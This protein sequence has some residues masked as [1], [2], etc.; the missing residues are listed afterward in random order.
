MK[1]A[2]LCIVF[3]LLIM[4]GCSGVDTKGT[5]AELRGRKVTVA[6]EEIDNGIDKAIASYQ[7]FLEDSKDVALIPEAIRRLADLKVEK[8]YGLIPSDGS[9]GENQ[10]AD[11]ETSR[12]LPL[13]A[14]K[15]IHD[16]SAHAAVFTDAP[17]TESEVD[18]ERFTEAGADSAIDANLDD[19]AKA[20][21]LEAIAL[22][23]KLLD[24]F[25]HYERNDQV[26]YQMCR[27]YEELGRIEEAIEVMNRL[28]GE[29]P[30]S[31][32]IDEVQFRRGEYFFTRRLY[33][34][35]EDAYA[36]IVEIGVASS[37]YPLAVYKLGWTF[38]KQELYE[39]A[40]HRFI[41]L[42]DYK[43]SIGY[44]FDQLE[45]EQERKRMD[46]TFRV[47]SLGFSYLGGADSVVDYFDRYGER[48]YAANI[49][50]NLGEYYFVK[51][52]Y[53]DAVAS[54]S[55]FLNGNPFHEKSPLFQMRIVEINLAGGFPSLVIEAKK[56]Y[57]VKY[58][59]TADYWL[60]FEPEERPEVLAYLKNNL[61]DLANHYHALYQ[62][63]EQKK[64]KTINFEE[65]RHW[66][67]MFLASFSHD[68]ESPRINYQLADLLLE[69]RDFAAAAVEYERT[70]YAYDPHEQ[71]SKAGYAAVF[72][73]RQHLKFIPEA[74]QET[75]KREVI[76]SSLAFSATFP[77]HDKAAI[78][79]AAAADDLYAL[80][81]YEHAV[82]AGQT[83]IETFPA[84]D[85]AVTRSAWLVVAHSC[86][87]LEV[88]DEAETAY[89]RVLDLLPEQDTSRQ[90]LNDNLAVSIYRQGEEARDTGNF[91]I[92]AEHFLRVASK[93][94]TSNIRPTAEYD[95]AAALMQI[96]AWER[97]ATV[98]TAF[99]TNFPGH[100]L[101]R[102]VTRKIA[103]VYRES[104]RYEL[105]A[106]EF[107]RVAAESGNDDLRR[108][109]LL[110]AAELYERCADKDQA[111]SVYR[112]FVSSF[113]RPLEP[114]IETR[115][116]IAE[117]LKGQK[118]ENEYLAELSMIVSLDA[119]AGSDRTERTRYLAGF[120]AL[121]LAEKSHERF[122]SIKLIKPFE[123]NLRKKQ[124][125]MK[126][127]TQEFTALIDYEI[128]EITAAATYYLAEIYAHF[129][130]SLMESERP[131]GLSPL[132]SEEYDLAIE[133]Q[134]YPFEEKAI[135]V[136]ESN[137]E[138]IALGVY[139]RWVE[140][141][142]ARLAGFVPSRYAKPVEQTTIIA[143][144]GTFS[145]FI[146]GTVPV[147]PSGN[148]EPALEQTSAEHL[149]PTDGVVAATPTGGQAT[150]HGNGATTAAAEATDAGSQHAEL[151]GMVH[152][153]LPP[154]QGD[155][156]GK[157]PDPVQPEA[158]PSSGAEPQQKE[159]HGVQEGA[160]TE[161][162]SRADLRSVSEADTDLAEPI[163][164]L[165]QE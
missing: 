151:P 68:Q 3:M 83:L 134:A 44:D 10:A 153:H 141:S 93:A 146:A 139:N 31:R 110:V 2:V 6:E 46:D 75:V 73:Y 135:A 4:G 53:S 28:V 100:E 64:A 63:P 160:V 87:E 163:K 116:K 79:L 30:Q 117:L 17:S 76:R 137:L 50:A 57:A 111:L 140:K 37:F 11:F 1:R 13:A 128:G 120:S 38:Y 107:E 7:K 121:V 114:N 157:Q 88:F 34:D 112:R 81:D 49:Y 16:P 24:E 21:P 91:K 129:S 80:E 148:M 122:E 25:P 94:P 56:T 96:K 69:N 138:L 26:L 20:G 59:L 22:Y 164:S 124:K 159:S 97:A 85:S 15:A 136:H 144:P 113:P 23:Q 48:S 70:A 35:A 115:N 5:I 127:A 99:R 156:S 152:R 67:R 45:D 106:P 154:K 72:A 65:A 18:W 165:N 12:P 105:A 123:V 130:K 155:D 32:Y 33:L 51:R 41:A 78:V 77:R 125:Q 126:M 161:I 43:L 52:R 86:Y 54:Y 103:F 60:Y 90:T 55:A 150:L 9:H 39:E 95:A 118:R 162:V 71:A 133:E 131:E 66:Y 58:G 132:E 143:S 74:Q 119:A 108:E 8:E 27:A 147:T 29:Y 104:A 158:D 19:L 101:Q 98:L 89:T 36:D 40:L 84:A 47:I 62:N 42:L 61:A 149:A 142:L 92:A 102:E 14:T 145:Y 82:V 109:A